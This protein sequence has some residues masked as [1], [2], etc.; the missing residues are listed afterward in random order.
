MKVIEVDD[1]GTE[2]EIELEGVEF[3]ELP[4][5]LNA[6]HPSWRSIKK[7]DNKDEKPN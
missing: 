5:I 6:T 7:V 4:N 2:R 3:I 1:D